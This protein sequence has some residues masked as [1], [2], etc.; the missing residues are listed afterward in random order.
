MK[1][2]YDLLIIGGGPGGAIAAKT[3]ACKGLS[4]CLV[5]K[6]PAIGVPVRCAEGIG[7]DI[8]QQF[9]EPDERWIS[10]EIDRAI[11]VS[12]DGTSMVLEPQHAGNE[13]GYVLDR[14]IFDRELVWQAAA[15]GADIA[16]KTRAVAPIME[17]G[18]VSGATI[19]S[20]GEVKN[21][22]AEAVIAADGVESKFARWCGIDTTVPLREIMSCAQY[23]MTNL[24]IDP[25]ATVF[26]FGNSIAP[27]GY[28]WVFPKGER[29]ANVGI[30]I[31]GRKSAPGKR[32]KDYLD[33]F[34]RSHFPDGRT[35]ECIV[36]GV[37]VC[38]PLPCTVADGLLIVG[39]A[40]RVV[41]PLTGG[42]IFNAMYTGQLAADVA[43]GAIAEGNTLKERLMPY[44]T[45]WR[46]AKLGK[47]LER[48]YKIKEFFIGLSDKKLNALAQSVSKI[49][50]KEFS[51]LV[52]VKELIKRNPGLILDLKALKDAIS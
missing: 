12:P 45:T 19:E 42:G 46:C 22:R 24:T 36:G 31:T 8:L 21:V 29:S 18:K 2:R 34:V 14:K 1:D 44:D 10:A 15:A 7:K 49:N 40:A 20:C 17:N 27:E 41:D 37:S 33:A 5:E 11:L 28:L 13:V 26:Y 4:V 38:R 3:A 43:A 25:H 35:I 48:N 50:L 6:R 32:A 16:V 30:G 51:T 39:D 23:L 9:I 52:L 47:N